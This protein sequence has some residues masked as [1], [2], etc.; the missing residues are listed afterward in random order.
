MIEKFFGSKIYYY[1]KGKKAI[2]KILKKS[3]NILRN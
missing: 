1:L 2:E 3:L